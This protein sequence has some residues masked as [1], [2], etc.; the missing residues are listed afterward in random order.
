MFSSLLHRTNAILHKAAATRLK[1]VIDPGEAQ[2]LNL[3]PWLSAL[4][5]L[6][7][8]FTERLQQPERCQHQGSVEFLQSFW[9]RC[10]VIRARATREQSHAAHCERQGEGETYL[11][12]WVAQAVLVSSLQ[13]FVLDL[14]PCKLKFLPLSCV[15]FALTATAMG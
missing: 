7:C 9:M 15:D 1:R 11:Q 3:S 8:V 14:G 6:I 13:M 10:N 4:L 5:R 12:G 2:A